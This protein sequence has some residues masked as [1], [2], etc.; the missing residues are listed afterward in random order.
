MDKEIEKLKK[1]KKGNRCPR[2]DGY[3]QTPKIVT[4]VFFLRLSHRPYSF[5][6]ADSFFTDPCSPGSI[7]MILSIL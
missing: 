2:T 6:R 5:T 1:K 7:E 4:S 3:L